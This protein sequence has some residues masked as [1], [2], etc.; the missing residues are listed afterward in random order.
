MCYQI[1]TRDING[2]EGPLL[3]DEEVAQIHEVVEAKSLDA[4]A[5]GNLPAGREL[6][7]I[8]ALDLGTV[9]WSL[10]PIKF[11]KQLGLP[12]EDKG[13]DSL[14]LNLSMAVQAKDYT[15][16]TVPYA[17]LA[18]FHF[19]VR[20]DRSPLKDKV[21]KMVVATSE[22]TKLSPHWQEYSG[23]I[24][25]KYAADDVEFWRQKAQSER[26]QGEE[27]LK[28]MGK[29]L[30][31][32]PHQVECL[33]ACWNFMKNTSQ[34]DYFVQMATGTGKS[35]VMSDL[36]AGLGP[37][38]CSCVVVPKLDLM[39]QLAQLLESTLSSRIARVGTGH[40]ADLSAQVFVCV[41][42]SAW[43]LSNL[44]FD[45][46]IFD[47]AHHYEPSPPGEREVE[48]TLQSSGIHTQQ[49]LALN[50]LKRIWFT[51]TLRRN[52]ANF[53]FGLRPAIE[54]GVIKDYSLLVPV[55]TSGDPRPSLVQ[56]IHNL[57]LSRKILA[58]C[59]TVQEAKGFTSM[60]LDA[61]IAADHYNG[62][63]AG[64]RRQ[65]VLKR[66]QCSERLRGIR[67]LVTVDVLSEGVDLPMADTCLFVA[68]RQGI[69]LQQCVGRVLRNHS[70]KLDALVIAPPLI[71][72]SDGTLDED[73]QLGRLLMELAR[74]DHV[75]QASLSAGESGGSRVT[76]A[77]DMSVSNSIMEEAARI[78][79]IRVLP[80][81]LR[82]CAGLDAWE[83]GFQGLLAYHGK[84]GHSL[85]RYNYKTS[86]GFSLG[87]WTSRQRNA[88]R[89][90]RLSPER[91]DRLDKLEFAWGACRQKWETS[92]QE[93]EKYKAEHGNV[94]VP[95]IYQ[96]VGGFNLARWVR[97]QRSARKRDKLAQSQIERLDEL[98]FVWDACCQK[99]ETAYQELEKYEAEHG[100]VLVPSIYQTVGGFNLGSWVRTQRSARKRDKLAQGQIE[101]LDELGFVWSARR[102]WEQAYEELQKYKIEHGDV[103]VPQSY[104][105]VSGFNLG[106]WV[107]TRRTLK[108]RDKLAQGQIESLDELG[109]VWDM[110]SLS[111]QV[112]QQ[113]PGQQFWIGWWVRRLLE[114]LQGRGLE[115]LQT[116]ATVD[117]DMRRQPSGLEQTIV[118]RQALAAAIA[119]LTDWAPEI[120][121]PDLTLSAHD[122]WILL[123]FVLPKAQPAQDAKPKAEKAEKAE[124]G[125]VQDRV[126]LASASASLAVP[127]PNMVD[128]VLQIDGATLEGHGGYGDW[129]QG[130]RPVEMVFKG[131]T[132]V[133]SPPGR[134]PAGAFEI[135]APQVDYVQLV[136]FPML[137]KLF[138][139]TLEMEVKQRGFLQGGGEV[140]VRWQLKKRAAGAAV[141][142]KERLPAAACPSANG[143]DACGLVVVLRSSTGCHFG[144]DSMGRKGAMAE[145]VGEEAARQAWAASDNGGCCDEHLEDD[146][147][148][149]AM[150]PC[151]GLQGV[152]C[153][154]WYPLE[155]PKNQL[156]PP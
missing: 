77:R 47:E 107:S 150:E 58:F 40:P 52:R 136:L 137:R 66:F 76:I 2:S 36:L 7:L 95:S 54:S 78:L 20:A 57:P 48:G 17:E 116:A 98:G 8:S 104:R 68:P 49:V 5:V 155:S 128:G 14:A 134:R 50:A 110:Q 124:P 135:T 133:C 13:I 41:R 43:Q 88:R 74:V 106:R 91:I 51:A 153:Q 1:W 119:K 60:L 81:A 132:N 39:E 46:V 53:D 141:V 12:L 93:L 79:R 42:N 11:K 3:S 25:Q 140:V 18:K 71:Q 97:M 143:A 127:A 82:R 27:M 146:Q 108:K 34:R 103:L 23:A 24:Q 80:N 86:D 83:V 99:W 120:K 131:G 84:H 122:D 16:G 33:K 118:F 65:E 31:R 67:V 22:T 126:A 38:K 121:A 35:L 62:K 149:G 113:L 112:L 130:G 142:L 56:T 123:G 129:T 156:V 148:H 72:N 96:T 32:W 87:Q 29:N 139:V 115:A 19:M 61:G 100:N 89:Q 70:Q 151:I 37:K 117:R 15:N 144:G 101:R 147:G 55:L 73:E 90:G 111:L 64:D 4:I 94:L 6:E 154:L 114:R 145:V 45:L 105:T 75:F 59:N 26:P 28:R 63:T 102:E 109:F 138:G 30:Q 9:P 152:W 92:Y 85:V 10:L 44:A 125:A 21:Q 69:R